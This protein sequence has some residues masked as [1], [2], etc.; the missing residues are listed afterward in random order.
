MDI[1]RIDSPRGHSR[2]LL[3]VALLFLVL[4]GGRTAAS[5]VIEYQWWQEMGQVSTW[6]NMLLYGT[7]PVAA[8][9]LLAA[10]LFWL[11]HMRGVKFSGSGRAS[12]WSLLGA[13][14]LG[15]LV[16]SA[17]IESWT[18]VRF[19]GGRGVSGGDAWRDPVFGHALS[20]YFFDLPFYAMLL[21]VVLTL[22][23]LSGLIFWVTTRAYQ[24]RGN[25][26]QWQRQGEVSIAELGLSG[27]LEAHFFR[28]AAALFLLVLAAQCYLDRFDMLLNEHVF[29]VGVDYVNETVGLPL[30]WLAVAACVLAAVLV[31][32]GRWKFVLIVPAAFAL[33]SLIPKMV[34]SLYVRPNE[35]SIQR[36]YIQRHIQATRAAYGL[37]HDV[38]EI[39][40]P[41]TME[42]RIDTSKHKALL[43]N[44]RLWDWRAFHDTVTQI[45]A[46]RPYYVFADS[47]VDRYTINGQLRQ[48]L[49]TPRELDIRQLPDAR[50]RWINPHFIYTH[51]YGIVMAEASRITP[52]GLPSLLIKDAPA[53]VEVPGLQITRPELYYGEVNHE[54]IF[55]GTGQAE[56]NYPSGSENVHSK[57][58]GQGG[59]PV[60]SLPMR[61][62]AAVAEGDWNILLTNLLSGDSRMMI[63]R[64]V[65]ERV[66]ALAGFITWDPDPYLV[67][68][69]EG[70]LV[71]MLDGYTTSTQHPYSRTIDLKGL[72][73][74]NYVRNS[75]KATIDAYDGKVNLYIFAPDDPII[76]AYARLFPALLKPAEAMPA[77]LREHARYPEVIFRAQA[78]IYR[79]FHMRDPEAFYNKEDLWDIAKNISGQAGKPEMLT[80]TYVVAT[81]P[82][83]DKPE[84]LLML[85]FT[86]RNKD[87][88]IGMMV[89]RCDGPNL[90]QIVFL[91]LSKQALIFGPM[92]IEARINQ[93]Q[94]IS[95]DL[96]L[97]NQQGSQ[98]LR[99]QMLVL[100]IENTILYVEPLYIQASEARMPQLKKVAIAMGN[101]LIYTDTYEEGIA[102]LGGMR[103]ATPAVKTAAIPGQPPAAAPAPSAESEKR[104]EA[105]RGRF[106]RYRDLM[107]QGKWAEAGRELEAIGS[108]I[109]RK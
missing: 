105:L 100:P 14:V 56:F 89:A 37:D 40:F 73:S 91:Q 8:A 98:V 34:N 86:P 46:L 7:L 1:R 22:A 102:Q 27:G 41:A 47:D 51:G 81:L 3:V 28:G 84:F 57:Y 25:I 48:V 88:L 16:A 101:T 38:K 10:V 94:M 6:F 104:L 15:F 52:D 60:A 17:L 42:A 77:D 106:Q 11:A 103:Q 99:G 68:T 12:G 29:L 107:A 55:V 32:M 43:D 87:N 50:T 20:F 54:P 65:V 75:V 5:Y 95:K 78:E 30:I 45:Q 85:P 2:V 71:W 13:L 76:R 80:P 21:R 9:S 96:S 62:A 24:L 49:L 108:E 26:A 70:R 53:K 90:G 64:K 59:F 109:N 4:I 31:A 36:P 69:K 97:W 67:L 66:G 39:E 74:F 72:G 35:I 63:R 83:A 61:L 44:V 33:Q 19:F 92:Q 79:T 58:D 93:D 18:V 82:D 23:L